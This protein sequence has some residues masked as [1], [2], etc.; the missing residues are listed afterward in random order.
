MSELPAGR[1]VLL[2]CGY[3]ETMPEPEWGYVTSWDD[4]KDCEV[5]FPIA[6]GF[7]L[8]D[9]MTDEEWTPG[10]EYDGRAR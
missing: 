7:K 6:A 5:V 4:W 9:S 2:H 10:S 3:D 8:V 1:F